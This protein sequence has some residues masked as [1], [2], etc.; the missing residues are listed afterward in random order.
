MIDARLHADLLHGV[1]LARR[2]RLAA[3]DHPEASFSE[4]PELVKFLRHGRALLP[5]VEI[6]QLAAL[7]RPFEGRQVDRQ[8]FYGCA[9]DRI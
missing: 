9:V 5:H 6:E 7:V 8:S 4:H 1:H 2:P 3:V